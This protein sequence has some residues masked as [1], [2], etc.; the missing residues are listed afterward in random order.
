MAR[1]GDGDESSVEARQPRQAKALRSGTRLGIL[2]FFLV[3][4]F[5]VTWQFLSRQA[6]PAPPPPSPSQPTGT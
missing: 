2:W 1:M 3:L 4:A 6:P 5:L